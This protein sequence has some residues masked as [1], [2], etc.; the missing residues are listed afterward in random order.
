VPFSTLDRYLL[1]NVA[2]TLASVFGLTV[3]LMLFEHLP[4]L[5]EIVRLSGRKGFIVMQSL[6]ALV[7]EYAGIGL[8]FGLYLAIA[9][10][11]RRLSLRAELDV[12]EA[13]GVP[14]RRW[15]R[16]PAVVALAVAALLLWTQG[17]LMPAG[18]RRLSDLSREM[19]DGSLGFALEV[20]QFVDL[21]KGVSVRFDRIEP[22]TGA[23]GGVFVRDGD[24]VFAARRGRLGFDLEGDVLV[25][26]EQGLSI[27]GIDRQALSFSHFHFDSGRQSV[28]GGAPNR[29]ELR[30]GMSVPQLLA[31]R[32]GVDLAAAWSRL[33]WPTFALLVPILALV[34][35]KPARRTAGSAGLMAGLV[36]LLL[37]I[38]S[39]GMVATAGAAYPATLA[40][41][42]MLAWSAITALLV[43]GERRWGAGYVDAWLRGAGT[44]V[45]RRRSRD[46]E[47]FAGSTEDQNPPRRH[48]V[49]M[50]GASSWKQ[51]RYDRSS[52]THIGGHTGPGTPRPSASI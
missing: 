48:E 6:L 7:P 24:T 9:L 33:L 16:A 12:I 35:G 47:E 44:R 38:R 5:F 36:V 4:R 18:E 29:S 45:A 1:R 50:P 46:G 8:L 10:T 39:A 43:Y 30:K 52:M 42:V 13:M 17:W 3:T 27:T 15:M 25:D 51:R 22:A 37:F 19:Q 28:G 31:S 21:G 49:Q 26:L 41:G 40:L 23:L 11:V 32:D 34:F 20:G 2:A 14:P